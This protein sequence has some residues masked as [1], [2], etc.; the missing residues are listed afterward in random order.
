VPRSRYGEATGITQTV[1]NF[2]SSLGLAVLGTVL[3]LEN[4]SNLEST[5]GAEGLPKSQADQIADA[6]SQSGGG[7]E[8]AFAEHGGAQAKMIFSAVQHDFALASQTVFYA[9]A[10]VMAVAFVVA[11]IWMPSGKAEEIPE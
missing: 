5:L 10:G 4:K 1:R 9:M 11:L 8:S 7:N 3:I 2:G 6:I